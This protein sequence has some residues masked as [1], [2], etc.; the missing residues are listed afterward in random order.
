MRAYVKQRQF[1][2]QSAA[3]SLCM[4]N[5]FFPPPNPFAVVIAEALQLTRAL[6]DTLDTKKPDSRRAFMF[7]VERNVRDA[8]A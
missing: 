1:S 3:N 7:H 6:P 5:G 2:H 4:R 8:A